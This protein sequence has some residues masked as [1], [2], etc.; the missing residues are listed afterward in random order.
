M[1]SQRNLSK[2]FSAWGLCGILRRTKAGLLCWGAALFQTWSLGQALP[3]SVEMQLKAAGIATSHL[4]VVVRALDGLSNGGSPTKAL[5]SHQADEARTPAS[6]MKLLTTQVA[7]DQLGPGF[8]WKTTFYK[9]GELRSDGVLSG[10]LY[11]KGGGDPKLSLEVAWRMLQKLRAFGV[12]RIQGD[13][14]FD[15]S[16]FEPMTQDPSAFDD[17]P[18]RPYNVGADALLINFNALLLTFVPDLQAGVAR[19]QVQ[20]P[21]QGLVVQPTVALVKGACNDY[22]AA[23]KVSFESANALQFKGVYPQE[24]AERTWPLAYPKPQEYT[25]RALAGMWSALGGTVS[26]NVRLGLVPSELRPLWEESSATLAQ[27]IRDMNKYSNNVMAQQLF[28]SLSLDGSRPA[29]FEQ[30]QAKVK[31]WWTQN[32]PKTQPVP[33]IDKGSGLS[34]IESI[35]ANGLADVLE[36]AWRSPWMPEFVASLP[37]VGQEG[38]LQKSDLGVMAHLK[39]GSLRDVLGVAGYVQT[40]FGERFLVVAMVNDPKARAARL[41]LDALISWVGDQ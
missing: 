27:I 22:R 1:Q 20:P 37:I 12:K 35:S 5:L 28:L 32:M 3:A 14:V 29:S 17:Q 26:G 36:W 7:L 31:A 23:L 8:T 4:S 39:T 16:V 15:K 21:L 33:V 9:E 13:L 11:I 40:R 10:N 24:C 38:T 41:A 6:L 30:S 18:L 19:V 25:Q 2:R 34:R